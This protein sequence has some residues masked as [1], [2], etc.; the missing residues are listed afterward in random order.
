MSDDKQPRSDPR[1]ILI[2]E[3]DFLVAGDV[4]HALEGAG[5]TVVGVATTAQEAITLARNERPALTIMDVRL[6]GVRDGI[7]AAIEIFRDLG[8]RSIFATAHADPR[9]IAR[10]QAANPAAWL[11][12]P[13]SR[14]LLLDTVRGVLSLG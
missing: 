4:E 12:K 14:K 7:D 10:A 2:V 3:D 13:Y 1:R 9:T 5:F 6:N 8:I 11:Q